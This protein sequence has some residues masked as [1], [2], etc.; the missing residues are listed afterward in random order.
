[1]PPK[2]YYYYGN[3]ILYSLTKEA[4]SEKDSKDYEK[5]I[6]LWVRFYLWDLWNH[7]FRLV[8]DVVE[9]NNEFESNVP[10]KFLRGDELVLEDNDEVVLS[11]PHPVSLIN[12]F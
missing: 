3:K 8:E 4:N 2:P 5:V 11:Q 10:V 6:E 1:M 7:G 12:K 9:E